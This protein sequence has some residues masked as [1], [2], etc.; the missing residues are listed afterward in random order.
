MR[1]FDQAAPSTIVVHLTPYA[2]RCLHLPVDNPKR[3]RTFYGRP[4][5][6][7]MRATLARLERA[8]KDVRVRTDDPPIDDIDL[9]AAVEDL[10]D[11][12]VATICS[13]VTA[14]EVTAILKR[15]AEQDWR[16]A[17]LL[18]SAA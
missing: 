15:L 2:P 10:G 16:P 7:V 18:K 13:G 4:P 6:A 17:T 14:A 5:E 11:V 9:I 12:P 8:A 3:W 1:I